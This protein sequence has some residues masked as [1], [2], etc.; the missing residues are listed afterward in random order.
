MHGFTC[1][2]GS[3]MTLG[4]LV[5]RKG[6]PMQRKVV[7][8]IRNC[9]ARVLT[10]DERLSW[11]LQDVE[12]N[13]A[14]RAVG[15]GGDEIST[16]QVLTIEQAEPALPPFGHG[17]SI[18]LLD[19]VGPRLRTVLQD[20]AS[21]VLPDDGR[22][23]PKLQAKVHIKAGEEKAAMVLR[24][25]NQRVLSGLFGVK[26]AAVTPSG[27]P[28]LRVIMNLIPSN[29]V[30]EELAG[31]IGALPNISQRVSLVLEEGCALQIFQSDMAS[32]FYLFQLPQCWQG[33]LA[34]NLRTRGENIP[35]GLAGETYFL[36]CNVLPMG[37]A[38]SVSIM[39][40][41]SENLLLRAG[42]EV[43]RQL[44]RERPLPRWMVE[45]VNLAQQHGSHWWHVYLDNFCAV[46]KVCSGAKSDAGE[47]LH[48][49][50]EDAWAQAKVLSAK[51]K[52][53]HAAS[54]ATELG[55]F[56]DG[57]LG[58][59]GAS[60]ERLHKTVKLSLH[61]LTL[62]RIPLKVL[63][64][65]AGRW[66]FI[67]QFR[68][69]AMTQLQEVWRFLGRPW[70]RSRK[71]FAVQWELLRACCGSM[72][73]HT[74]LRAAV[75][76]DISCSDASAKGGAVAIS[77]QL[78]SEGQDFLQ[79]KLDCQMLPLSA[80]ILVISLFDG[81]GGAFRCYDLVGIEPA[82][83]IAVECHKPACRVTR[84][85]WPTCMQYDDVRQLSQTDVRQWAN[86]WG[87][88][89]AVHLWAGCPCD[90]V[91]A[92][93]AERGNLWG[94]H[95]SLFWEIERIYRLLAAEFTTAQVHFVVENVHS[96]NAA[97]RQAISQAIGV[98]P[99]MLDPSKQVPMCRPRL[100]WTTANLGALTDVE[101]LDRDDRWEAV[102]PGNW[103]A[104]EVL[105]RS[106]DADPA[107]NVHEGD[108]TSAAPRK[109]SRT[110]SG[111]W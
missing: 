22:E 17:G 48:W 101:L 5:E 33:H 57:E 30:H 3:A 108:Q 50:A 1:L 61:A 95:S 42:F 75:G 78:S 26:K 14:E 12:Q 44:Q 84:K 38:S 35:G 37:W 27:S 16:L 54:V 2:C 104:E 94:K 103:P 28:V 64:I 46:E 83:R 102:V 62:K 88:L 91:S 73:Y 47:R 105:G 11:A 82:G 89:K 4:S 34:F 49:M 77:R 79:S 68:R 67:W 24:Y 109:P 76:D 110:A 90:G 98:K 60:P 85:R 52:R 8:S 87:H 86:K 99:V 55:A 10:R 96:M 71:R 7:E 9:V 56:I 92:I 23:L 58:W 20:P 40:E 6:S 51:K 53:V 80:E 63:Q 107:A 65:A 72:L 29:A 100:C 59:L 36:A 18:K 81:V 106:S 32:A 93:K 74:N 15:Y 41:V 66:I 39:Q 111:W 31:R 43:E 21:C 97:A 45:S 70:E 69:P 25:R 13:L 19:W